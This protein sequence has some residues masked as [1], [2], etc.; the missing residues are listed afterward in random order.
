M[1]LAGYSRIKKEMN[2]SINSM[3]NKNPEG[4]DIDVVFYQ[5]DNMYGLGQLSVRRRLTLLEKVGMIRIE[6]NM[7]IKE[8]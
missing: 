7:I 4:I 8:S 2:D 3:I 5:I 1:R 6:G